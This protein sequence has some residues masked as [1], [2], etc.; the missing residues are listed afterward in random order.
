MSSKNEEARERLVEAL[1]ERVDASGDRALK[2]EELKISCDCLLILLQGNL[3]QGN[4]RVINEKESAPDGD[5]LRG[6][7]E[8]LESALSLRS[9]FQRS[10]PPRG[11]I[12]S[13]SASR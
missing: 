2:P 6:R 10:A 11:D 12:V 9:A 1:L 13:G 8:R 4:E 3:L 5:G 7:V